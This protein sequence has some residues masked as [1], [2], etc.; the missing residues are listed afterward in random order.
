[1][2]GCIGATSSLF[3]GGTAVVRVAFTV[4]R[5]HRALPFRS[6]VVCLRR[7]SNEGE[8]GGQRETTFIHR[9]RPRLFTERIKK[10]VALTLSPD[11]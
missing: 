11:P 8:D 4:L 2:D 3:I 6:P 9:E 5:T 10:R 7:Q 1:M